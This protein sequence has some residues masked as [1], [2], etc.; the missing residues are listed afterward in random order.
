MINSEGYNQPT[1]ASVKFKYRC[2]KCE[3]EHI[4]EYGD[5]IQKFP[6]TILCSCGEEIK[7]RPMKRVK[8]GI[9]WGGRRGKR[10]INQAKAEQNPNIADAI[11]ALVNLG[12]TKTQAK[13]M[14]KQFQYTNKSVEEILQA[15]FIQGLKK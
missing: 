9:V 12:H 10:V 4:I 8:V 13:E 1:G 5:G 14:T 15:V 2:V 6:G 3:I 11:S 7:L